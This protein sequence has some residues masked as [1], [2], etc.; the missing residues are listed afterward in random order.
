MNDIL[1]QLVP[2][3]KPAVYFLTAIALGLFAAFRYDYRK[4]PEPTLIAA[5]LTLSVMRRILTLG[6]TKK[7]EMPTREPEPV[8]ALPTQR[9]RPTPTDMST[10]SRPI[11]AIPPM[12][13]S[14]EEPPE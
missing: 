8:D 14:L 13:R 6:M 10:I 11:Q 9:R 12:R 5:K 4:M 1:Q 3:A 7:I 2:L